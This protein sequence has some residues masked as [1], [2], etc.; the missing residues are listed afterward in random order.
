M[1]WIDRLLDH[2]PNMTDMAG[3]MLM[4]GG[5]AGI[6]AGLMLANPPL[7]LGAVL[8][9]LAGWTGPALSA[10]KQERKTPQL[11]LSPLQQAGEDAAVAA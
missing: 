2:A 1:A 4:V 6:A 5:T 8:V 3:G 11:N 10:M 9:W 7:C